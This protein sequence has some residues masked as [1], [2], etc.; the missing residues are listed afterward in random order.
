M[1]LGDNGRPTV[2]QLAERYATESEIVGRTPQAGLPWFAWPG[3]GEIVYTDE[4]HNTICGKCASELV[5]E[6]ASETDPDERAMVTRVID[7]YVYHEGATFFCD[8]CNA[9]I[10]SMYGD[11]FEDEDEDKDAQQPVK[12]SAHSIA[13]IHAHRAANHMDR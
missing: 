10:K 13:L 9:E 5:Q 3:G 11:P 7:W 8:E 4:F 12:L 1:A 2:D 6:L